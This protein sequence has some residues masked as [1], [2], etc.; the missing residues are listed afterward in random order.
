[1][2]TR[3]RLHL[4]LTQVWSRHEPDHLQMWSG[5]FVSIPAV[6]CVFC[7][8]PYNS[9]IDCARYETELIHYLSYVLYRLTV[10]CL[11][12][13]LAHY[14]DGH[15]IYNTHTHRYMKTVA[16]KTKFIKHTNTHTHTLMLIWQPC[17][18]TSLTVNTPHTH[19]DTH[20]C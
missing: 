19:T 4:H 8:F 12:L 10:H 20:T 18:D 17:I 9:L 14:S 16:G 13:S 11:L 1:M 6:S 5:L 3:C 2:I 7:L 15:H